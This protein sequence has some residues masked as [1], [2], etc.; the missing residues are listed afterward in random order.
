MVLPAPGVV[1]V[2]SSEDGAPNPDTQPLIMWISHDNGTTFSAPVEVGISGGTSN[3]GAFNTSSAVA[4]GGDVVTLDQEGGQERVFPADGSAPSTAVVPLEPDELAGGSEVAE[5][6]STAAPAIAVLGDGSLITAHTRIDLNPDVTIVQTQA[7]PGAAP[8]TIATLPG[9]DIRSLVTG[10]GGTF[11]MTRSTDEDT[12]ASDT[13]LVRKIANGV[14]GGAQKVPRGEAYD[15]DGYRLAEDAQGTLHAFWLGGVLD[16]AFTA[17][18]TNGGKSWTTH[19]LS[20]LGLSGT[21]EIS[22][23]PQGYGVALA[24]GDQTPAYIQP[25]LIYPT[26]TLKVAKS[27]VAVGTKISFSG[28]VSPAVNGTKVTLQQVTGKHLTTVGT[29]KE[30]KDGSF[31]LT[32]TEHSAGSRS[33]DAFVDGTYGIYDTATSKTVGVKAFVPRT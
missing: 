12:S 20:S 9:E 21:A 11:I 16:R 27:S 22:L 3:S 18:S 33:F 8:T 2:L 23:A 25:L 17:I 29:A 4:D 32:L 30:A 14:L 15:S 26:V 1:D 7:A 28:K 24:A 5:I 31:S 6:D 19:G 13:V 10:P